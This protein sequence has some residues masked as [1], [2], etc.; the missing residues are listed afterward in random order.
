MVSG[1][2]ELKELNT[3]TSFGQAQRPTLHDYSD[4]VDTI[5]FLQEIK[6]RRSII[7]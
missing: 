1:M 3:V 2:D 5:K 6:H 7:E 4:N